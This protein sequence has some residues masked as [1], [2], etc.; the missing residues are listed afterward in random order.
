MSLESES[1]LCTRVRSPFA[2]IYTGLVRV[3]IIYAYLYMYI[4]LYY[5][6]SIMLNNTYIL[7]NRDTNKKKY[8]VQA[9][10]ISC[11]CDDTNSTT[12]YY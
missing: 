5:I 12:H 6:A 4:L 9:F 10:F 7:L 8:I 11:H 3:N 1:E 2:L